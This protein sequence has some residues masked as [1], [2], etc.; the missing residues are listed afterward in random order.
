[1]ELIAEI[2]GNHKG[3]WSQ[4]L[5]LVSDACKS[6]SDVIKLQLYSAD[7]LVSKNTDKIRHEHFKQFELSK[8]EYIELFKLIK[9]SGKKVCASVW[10][11]NMLHWA[12]P[13]I[14]VVKIGSGDFTYLPLVLEL[15]SYKKEVII[16]SGLSTADEVDKVMGFI[17]SNVT[18]EYFCSNITLMQCT[19]MYPIP[20]KEANLEV[21]NSFKQK[22][23]CKIGYSD[24]TMGIDALKTAI[25]IGVDSVEFHYTLNK[26]DN[27]FRDN[28][29]SLER[30]EVEKLKLFISNIDTLKGSKQ[31]KPTDSEISSNHVYSFRRGC[32][33]KRDLSKGEVIKSSDIM[34]LRPHGPGC[35]SPLYFDSKLKTYVVTSDVKKGEVII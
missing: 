34:F 13:F 12:L 19:S 5:E 11:V 2:G 18:E 23:D 29:V 1:M 3:N 10:D 30:L 31:K 33:A 25:A 27:S 24:H 4:A 8:N 28:L 6:S 14:D 35:L 7:G 20:H 16:S 17:Q 26:A 9:K 32:Y 15:L 21:I 22:Y